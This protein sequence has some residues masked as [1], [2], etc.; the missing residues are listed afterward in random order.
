MKIND[1]ASKYQPERRKDTVNRF[2]GEYAQGIDSKNRVFIPAKFREML[3]EKI[4]IT[5]NFEGC[6]SVYSEAGWD[7]YADKLL[8]LPTTEGSGL[9][10]FIFSSTIDVKLDS[11]G[12]VVLS[13][14]LKE[15]AGLSKDIYI[16]GMGDHLEIWDKDRFEGENTVE[17]VSGYIDVLKKNSF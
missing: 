5:R 17:K 10:R 14:S 9:M 16:I 7:E 1:F 8:S 4:F 12:R 3:G 11:Q 2:V 6:L 13:P 15:Y